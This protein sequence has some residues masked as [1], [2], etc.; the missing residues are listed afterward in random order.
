V[1]A[2]QHD[3][4]IVLPDRAVLSR[5]AAERFVAAAGAAVARHGGFTVALS[6]GST[7]RDLFRLL[8]R[9]PWRDQVDWSRTKVFWGDERCVAPDDERSN[10]RLAQDNLL[11]QVPLPASNIFPMIR[12][13]FV[14][15]PT[16]WAPRAAQHE[17]E[18]KM[19]VPPDASGLPSFDLILLGLGD[20]GHTASLLPGSR[21]VDEQQ[22]LVALTD[23]QREG[24]SRL[25]FTPPL[26]QHAA[27]LLFL[28]AG[29][30]K[31]A[32]L[33]EV[34]EGEPRV[35]RYPAQV[36]RQALGRVVWLVDSAAAAELK[37]AGRA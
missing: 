15:D 24:T 9:D 31:A 4:V 25:T 19:Q 20:D 36:A 1:S 32:A 28:L 2:E 29:A 22:Q 7:P 17:A 14:D 21:L 11:S 26:L 12:P 6:G 34:L 16:T 37:E 33:A 30:D 23:L 5:T 8:A 35:E 13:D 3:T 18:I 10:F 27:E